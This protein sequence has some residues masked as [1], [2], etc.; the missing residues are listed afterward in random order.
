MPLRFRK[1]AADPNRMKI[2]FVLP[3][4]TPRPTGG[5]K[6]VYQYANALAEAG[7]EVEVLHPRTLF[8]WRFRPTTRTKLRSLAAD[9]AK[10]AGVGHGREPATVPWMK[11]HADVKISV[12]PALYSRYMPDADVVVASLWRTAEYV[13]RLPAS[14]G[15]QFYFIQHYET[16][17]GPEQRVNRTLRSSLRKIVI[18]SWLGDLVHELSGEAAWQV[19]NPVDHDEFFVTAPLDERTRTVSMLYSPHTWKGAAEGVA[20]L[21]QAKA[22]FPDLRARVFGT[23]AR[24]ALLPDW[25]D[26][27][28]DAPRHVL[29]ESIYNAS[30]VYLCPSWS[31]GWGL[32]ALEAMAC[33]CAVVT[34]DNGGTRDF[35]V[36]GENGFVV[37]P[38]AAQPLGDA[39][40][41]LLGDD[42]RRTAFAARSIGLAKQFT[43]EASVHKLLDALAQ[44]RPVDAS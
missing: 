11:M 10:L 20:A 44:R 29:R 23:S 1:K 41:A 7:H 14:K 4:L 3:R 2:T 8:L 24:P 18:S 32:P 22:V 37:P 36:D 6:I 30:S 33:G 31:E 21:V 16:W 35:V 40:V 42:T 28:Q 34:A 25:I 12:V 19:P 38:K 26:Y 27:V 5:G 43:L 15:E 39:L 13:E 17:S 9:C